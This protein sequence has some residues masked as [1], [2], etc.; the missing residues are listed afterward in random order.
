MKFSTRARY[1]LRMMVEL[2][3]GLKES[4]VVSIGHI[5]EVT[6]ISPNYLAQ[7]AIPLKSSGLVR[8]ISGKKGGYQLA[9][10][11]K[12]ISVGDVVSA[13][14]GP[15]GLTDCVNS[16]DMC[17]NS[18]FCET[19]MIWVLASHKMSEL[20]ESV[21]LADMVDKRWKEKTRKKFSYVPLLDPDA[22]LASDGNGDGPS[23]ICPASP[24]GQ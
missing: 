21:S 17:L 6:G 18:S 11:A 24:K 8:G 3:R 15:V 4:E 12:E 13:V 20:F 7:L 23:H 14:L 9:R 5:A 22:H 10:P 16:P 1:G 2:S 19:R